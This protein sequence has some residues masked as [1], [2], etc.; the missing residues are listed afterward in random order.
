MVIYPD[1]S[2]MASDAK[3]SQSN[4]E[5][6]SNVKLIVFAT[7]MLIVMLC[8]KPIYLIG[9]AKKIAISVLKSAKKEYQNIDIDYNIGQYWCE[10]V[11]SGLCN[12][13]FC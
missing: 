12:R 7:P 6:N 11:L 13:L 1:R 10:M 8:N 5:L 4:A 9:F 3:Y 2:H